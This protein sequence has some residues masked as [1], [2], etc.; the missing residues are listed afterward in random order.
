MSC[1]PSALLTSIHY[2]LLYFVT[3]D[4]Q[5]LFDVKIHGFLPFCA[6]V[7][8]SVKQLL[9]QSIIFSTPYGRFKNDLIPFTVWSMLALFVGVLLFPNNFSR[10]SWNVASLFLQHSC[11][12]TGDNV[13]VWYPDIV[14]LST[15]PTSTRPSFGVGHESIGSQDHYTGRSIGIVCVR[16]TLSKFHSTAGYGRV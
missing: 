6:A 9:P 1:I 3:S 16:Y 7:F 5:Y 13:H 11:R 10:F 8:V 4:L 14:V 2:I 12:R 15:F